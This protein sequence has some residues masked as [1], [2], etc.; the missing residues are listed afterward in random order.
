MHK[1]K[2]SMRILNNKNSAFTLMEALISLLIISLIGLV[3]TSA[4]TSGTR[5][6]TKGNEKVKGVVK[7]LQTDIKIRSAAE[8]VCIPWWINECQISSTTDTITFPWQDGLPNECTVTVPSGISI[9]DFELIKVP[10][11][12]PAGI[13]VTCSYKSESFIIEALFASFPIGVIPL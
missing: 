4:F 13:K 9:I 10:Q 6:I 7:Q 5:S 2:P 12:H 1:L 3:I 11:Q 8:K